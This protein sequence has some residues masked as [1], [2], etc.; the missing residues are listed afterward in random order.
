M[1]RREDEIR[2]LLSIATDG[3]E[4]LHRCHMCTDKGD[5]SQHGHSKIASHAAF[6]FSPP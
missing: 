2:N 6:F 5:L 3:A 1:L 4:Q